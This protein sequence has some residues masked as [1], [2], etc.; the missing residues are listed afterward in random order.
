M[1]TTAKALPENSQ[2]EG[3]SII[4]EHRRRVPR[5]SAGWEGTCHIDGESD[6]RPRACRVIDISMLG[7]GMT[8]EHSSSPSNLLG[9][10]ISVDVPAV[11]DSVSI[12]LEGVV[13]NA[14]PTSEG[15]IRVGIA[16]NGP[17]DSEPGTP[18]DQIRKRIGRT[19]AGRAR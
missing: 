1:T 15:T 9:R 14:V 11:T 3:E 18:A 13:N 8:F 17:S 2:G 7:L 10:G 4:M 5:Q 19:S 6:E 16:F 12:R